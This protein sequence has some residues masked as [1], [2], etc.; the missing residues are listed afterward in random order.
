[1]TIPQEPRPAWSHGPVGVVG[2]GL[3]GGSLGLD[4]QARGAEVRALVHRAATAERA[5]ARGLATRV[6]TEPS[7]LEGCELVVLAL[8]L[9]RLL[10][11]PPELVAALPEAAV[12]TDVGSVKAP[13][14]RVWSEALTGIDRPEQVR[15]FVPSH[16]MAGTAE[17][18][19]EA[20]VPD[21]F[22]GRPWV[23]TPEASTDPAA[24]ALVADLAASLGA[25]WIS[26]GAAAHDR[27]VALIS[28]LPVLV[29]AALL[30]TADRGGERGGPDLAELV[31]AL[32]SSGFADTTRVGG[33][34]PELGTLMARCNRGAVLEALGTYRHCLEA[35][36]QEVRAEAW[37]PLQE[38]L[39]ACRDLRPQFL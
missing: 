15:R 26:C 25:R 23:V 24:L 29:S 14:Q 36:E 11:P 22:L 5:R 31:R 12:I 16:P 2:L 21:L 17:A 1:M 13:L 9:D 38:A 34:N 39:A 4:L 6:A 28:H 32:A 37:E 3:I 33:G 35:L 27:A 8:P 7:V 19:V 20:G 18:G 10:A 30:Q